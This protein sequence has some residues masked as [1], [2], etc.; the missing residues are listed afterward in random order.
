M[1][2]SDA[3]NMH[4]KTFAKLARKVMHEQFRNYLLA[5]DDP[6]KIRSFLVDQLQ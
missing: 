1:R 4:M 3:A 5:E 6:E 2:E